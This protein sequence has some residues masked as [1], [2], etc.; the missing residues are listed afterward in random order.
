M[1]YFYDRREFQTLLI[2]SAEAKFDSRTNASEFALGGLEAYLG[3]MILF[4]Q[5]D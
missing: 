2:N 1:G 5:I 3:L 4:G